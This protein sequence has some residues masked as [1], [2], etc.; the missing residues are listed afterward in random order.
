MATGVVRLG[1]DIEQ[2]G[3]HVVI[4]RL[5]V[6]K[7][8]GQQAQVLAVDLEAEKEDSHVGQECLNLPDQGLKITD[9]IM[10]VETESVVWSRGELSLPHEVRWRA[11]AVGSVGI[12]SA[13]T[14]LPATVRLPCFSCHPLRKRRWGLC[15]RFHRRVGVS[16]HI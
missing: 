15:G 11:N 13:A 12:H 10:A 5:V 9:A 4:Q 7:K 1:H 16:T 14:A 6:Q 8:L 3:L 2:E